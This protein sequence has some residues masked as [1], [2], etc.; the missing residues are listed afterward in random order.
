VKNLCLL[1]AT[2]FVAT[3]LAGAADELQ[4]VA[5]NAPYTM[6]PA[7]HYEHCTDPG[8]ATQL[9]DGKYVEGYFW[10][11]PGTVGWQSAKPVII[12]IDLKKDQ[13]IRGASFNTAAGAAGVAWPSA[14]FVF[15]AGEDKAW[16]AAG[17]LVALSAGQGQ[18]PAEGY[19]VH[20]YRTD[21]LKTH[22][23]YVAFGIWC[24]PFTFSD[25]IEV[26]AGDP[27][28]TAAP[29]E[30]K[31]VADL[32][33]YMS[34]LSTYEGVYRRLRNDINA[35]RAK[36]DTPGLAPEVKSAI[37]AELDSIEK[38]LPNLG[39]DYDSS[40]KAILPLNE[41]HAR[42]FRAHS[43][44]LAAT[45]GAAF[46]AWAPPNA[47]DFL[48]LLAEPPK[49]RNQGISVRMMQNEYR[50]AAMNFTNAGQEN[51]TAFS[52]SVTG[53]PGGTNPPWI[54]MHEVLWTDTNRSIPVAAALKP[55][56]RGSS[57][58]TQ[59]PL[60]MTRQV[61]LTFHPTDVPPGNYEGKFETRIGD[62]V[63]TSP[64]SLVIYPSR[65]PDKPRL[66]LGGWDYT[67]RPSHYQCT[68]ENKPA[69]IKHLREHYV[70]SP[71]ATAVVLPFGKY[72][73][74]G[75][76]TEP[77]ATAE[78]DSWLTLWPD[79]SQYC[80][81]PSVGDKCGDLKMGTAEFARAVGKWASFW[82]D[83]MKQKGLKPEQ[84][85]ILLVDE[86]R[87]PEHDAVI[88][89][90][91][92]AFRAANT[93]IRLWEDP[94]YKDMSKANAD[95]IAQCHILC[96]NRQIFLKE[97]QSYRDF[98]VQYQAKGAEL[99]FYSCSGPAR[100]LDPYSYYRLQAWTCRQYNAKSM[101]FWAYADGGGAFSFNEYVG[102][103]SGYTPLFI[104]P[105]S[106]MPG[107]QM[108]AIREGV[109]DFEYLAMLEDA[110]KAKP[111]AEPGTLDRAKKLLDEA[112]GRVLTPMSPQ[113][114]SWRPDVDRTTA[115]TVR[116]EIL[117]AIMALK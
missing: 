81:F 1:F 49:E 56:P 26:Y 97:P 11:Q 51:D 61:W 7:P 90:W 44:Y 29:L 19:A 39:K 40:F 99:E 18:P 113:N 77:P 107:K 23:R 86:P 62:K 116:V 96:P 100:V 84:L 21:A 13:A 109:E 48:P 37:V 6:E 54:T 60:G 103:D 24:E 75:E 93:G 59:V 105:D 43:A 12:T 117:Q 67:D 25:E 58:S 28:W 63:M 53:L 32:K 52:V 74:A 35:M 17:E 27:E 10:T 95:M 9:T 85:I 3:A 69:L 33:E 8:D 55:A 16:H 42:V 5:L 50:A 20:R 4:N 34:R 66:H 101:Y 106:I 57:L 47:Y 45:Y 91:A 111:N 112:P 92:K 88:L 94:I 70:D 73:A 2:V 38:E 114:F 110:I 98:Y 65:F 71:W 36:A 82:A 87:E 72:D 79:A 68:P 115:D 64:I 46:Y 14:I 80:V 76:M 89:E 30:G 15:V 83:H 31:P 108:E 41:L 104:E 102:K 78:F 22:G